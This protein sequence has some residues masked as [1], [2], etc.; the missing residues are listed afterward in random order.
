MTFGVI[1][2]FLA[3]LSLVLRFLPFSALDKL[4]NF[5]LA[6]QQARSV[7]ASAGWAKAL[8]L[9][10]LA[11]E[12]VLE[13]RGVQESYLA[14]TVVVSCRVVSCDALSSAVLRQ[15]SAGRNQ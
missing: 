6:R 14:D 15:A 13:R 7:V 10:G 3:R 2:T 5:D 9:T 1:L 4:L 11:V 12:V 8:I